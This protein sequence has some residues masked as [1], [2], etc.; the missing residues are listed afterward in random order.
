MRKYLK[1][2]ILLA[3]ALISTH[4]FG[5]KCGHDILE[6]ELKRQNPDY[7]PDWAEFISTVDF[8]SDQK[9]EGTV[10]TIPV[11]VHIIYDNASDNITDKQVKNAIEVLNEDYRRLN[12]DASDTRATL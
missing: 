5:Q 10:F 7:E 3:F 4:S 6:E 9:T 12:P 2:P 1:Y 11:V 8:D